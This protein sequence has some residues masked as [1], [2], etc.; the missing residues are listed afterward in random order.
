MSC[1]PDNSPCRRILFWSIFG[2]CRSVHSIRLLWHFHVDFCGVVYFWT[3][4]SMSFVKTTSYLVKATKPV[5]WSKSSYG[6]YRSSHCVQCAYPTPSKIPPRYTPCQRFRPRWQFRY[7]KL[8]GVKGSTPQNSS[9]RRKL[10]RMTKI[11]N[12]CIMFCVPSAHLFKGYYI[13][14]H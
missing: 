11:C 13:G 6:P 9:L 2:N 10:C 12:T 4:C 3:S 7:S 5:W 1:R 14:W 8:A